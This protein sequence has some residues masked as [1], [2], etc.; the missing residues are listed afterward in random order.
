[1]DMKLEVLLIP[2]SDV[3]RAVIKFLRFALISCE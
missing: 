2:V 1:M 3:D